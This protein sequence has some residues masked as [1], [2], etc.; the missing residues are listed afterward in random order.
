MPARTID[1]E[2][3]ILREPFILIT[4]NQHQHT[5]FLAFPYFFPY[6][7]F[8]SS[9]GGTSDAMI[10]D[11]IPRRSV[12]LSPRSVSSLACSTTSRDCSLELLSP[13]PVGRVV[14]SLSFG[15]NGCSSV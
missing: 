9:A 14:S 13:V 10:S 2:T 12:S 3:M 5:F 15:S 4:S 11:G 6:F 1:N 8:L 7:F